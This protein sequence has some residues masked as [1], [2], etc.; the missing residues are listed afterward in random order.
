[1]RD[2]GARLEHAR[3]AVTEALKALTAEVPRGLSE[4]AK[5]IARK[6]NLPISGKESDDEWGCDLDIE[7]MDARDVLETARVASMA[8]QLTKDASKQLD[9]GVSHGRR[10]TEHR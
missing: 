2:L 7:A 8:R 6:L 4:I 10:K 5:G 3:M 1:M 9:T